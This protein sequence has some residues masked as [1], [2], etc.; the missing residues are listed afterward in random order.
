MEKEQ[1]KLLLVAVSVGVFLLVTITAAMIMLTPRM[2]VQDT[3]FYSPAP[4]QPGRIQSENTETNQ[5]QPIINNT[6]E[7]NIFIDGNQDNPVNIQGNNRDNLTIQI[8]RP[9]AAAV[10]DTIESLTSVAANPAPV[11]PQVTVAPS[12]TSSPPVQTT[13]PPRTTS[14]STISTRTI[15]DYWIQVG[16][17]SAIVRAEDAKKLLE[18]KGFISIIENREFDGRIWYRVR[19]GPYTSE[20]EANYWL[21][22]VK[23]IDGFKDNQLPQ[24]QRPHIRQTTRQL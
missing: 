14:T 19:L 17:F 2:H 6:Q 1:K 16:A 4:I 12:R 7:T 20:N 10:P 21:T 18:T 22:L 5:L 13:N 24:D 8:P 9:T 15:I 11:K 3:A 23:E